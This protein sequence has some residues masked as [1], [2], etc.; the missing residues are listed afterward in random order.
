MIKETGLKLEFFQISGE[1]I[2]LFI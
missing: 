1:Q 2:V